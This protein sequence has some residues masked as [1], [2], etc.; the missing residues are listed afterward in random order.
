M[1][2]DHFLRAILPQYLPAWLSFRYGWPV[3]L[4][5]GASTLLYLLPLYDQAGLEDSP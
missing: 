3:R 1:E 5:H 2:D 4:L